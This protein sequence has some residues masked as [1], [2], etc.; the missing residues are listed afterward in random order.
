MKIL[1]VDDD[2][3]FRK[4]SQRVL[5]AYCPEFE[6]EEAAGLEGAQFTSLRAAAKGSPFDLII[7]DLNMPHANE[8]LDLIDLLRCKGVLAHTKIVLH[9]SEP[10]RAVAE[11]ALEFG[12]TGVIYK[13]EQSLISRLEELKLIKKK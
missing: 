11:Q 8:G 4:A 1:I 13:S 12:A 5:R 6:I 10:S 2:A 9:C 3:D 7:T